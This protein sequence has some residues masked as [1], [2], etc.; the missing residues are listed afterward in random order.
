MCTI[1]QDRI[2]KAIPFFKWL[3]SGGLAMVVDMLVLFMLVHFLGI[4]HVFAA[5]FAF[6]LSASLNY[7][8]SK[9]AIFHNAQNT[10]L[11][12][13]TTFMSISLFGLGAIALGM[14]VLVDLLGVHYLLARLCLAGTLGVSSFFLHKYISFNDR[15][16]TT[17]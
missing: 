11:R 8:I 5:S 10:M 1:M 13:Y 9:L 17:Q 16:T 15:K 12:S 7:T 6:F 2:K 3:I 14:F 4:Y